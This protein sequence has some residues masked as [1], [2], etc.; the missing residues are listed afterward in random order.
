VTVDFEPGYAFAPAHKDE[1]NPNK[2]KTG[3]GTIM[4]PL[5]TVEASKGFPD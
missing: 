1:T 5:H 4:I 3:P 2:A